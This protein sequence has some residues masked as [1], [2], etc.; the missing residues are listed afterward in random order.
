LHNEAIEECSKIEFKGW[1]I[2]YIN[3]V[4][5]KKEEA[6]AILDY[7]LELSKK[8]FVTPATIAFI[9]IGIGEKDKAFE[10]LEKAYEQ[11]TSYVYGLKVSSRF[12]SL[13]SDPRYQDL[14]ERLNYPE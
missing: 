3:G 13:R 8:E 9:Y 1:Q 12:D 10:W 11:R 14:V 7:Y 5:G 6:Q 4:A 2:G